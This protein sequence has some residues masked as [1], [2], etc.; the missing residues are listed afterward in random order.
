MLK[1]FLLA[2]SAALSLAV[3]GAGAANAADVTGRW[4]TAE[5]GGIVEI[6]PCGDS[7]CGRLVTSTKLAASPDLKDIKNKN[8]ALRSRLLRG[9]VVLQGFHR[10]GDGWSGGQLYHPPSGSTY[11]GEIRLAAPDRLEVTGCIVAP[12][13]QKQIWLRAK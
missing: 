12:L 8:P 3:V 13:C 10:D 5:Q 2:A 7:V 6:I 1:T 9:L 11:K 4:H